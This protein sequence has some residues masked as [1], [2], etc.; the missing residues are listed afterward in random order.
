MRPYWHNLF[1][2]LQ[3]DPGEG[4]PPG[5]VVRAG[6]A[7]ASRLYGLG[8]GLRR[9]LY[10]RGWLTV[11]RLPAPVVSVGNLTVGGTGKTPVTACLARLLQDRGQRVAILSRGYGGQSRNVACI[12]DGRHIYKKPPEVGE[13][14]YWLARTLPGVAV[15]TGACRY[16]AGLAAWQEFKPDLFLLDD[17]FQH[18]QLHRDL[19]L[20][21]LDAASPFGNHRLLPRGPLRE[22]LTALAAAQCFILTR[23]DPERHQGQLAAIRAAFPDKPVLTATIIPVSV[24]AY[25]GGRANALAAMRHRAL[26]AFAGLARPEVFTVTL[27]ELG[28]DLKGCRIFPDHH[29]YSQEELD[30]L[31]AA[32]RSLGAEGL[33]TTAKDWARLGERWDGELPLWVLEVEARLGDAEPVLEL[34]ERSCA[35]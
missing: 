22:P 18:F 17:G 24:T 27:E 4:P 28:V 14:P 34:L 32:A 33:V 6:A 23:F 8:A 9:S 15:Y 3:G 21:L 2:R 1:R 5:P 12:S 20:V 30:C 25:P 31:A 13:E 26:M 10:A 16:A 11:R 29:A 35:G 19:D 7:A